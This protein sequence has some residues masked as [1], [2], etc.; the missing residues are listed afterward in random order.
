MLAILCVVSSASATNLKVTVSEL[1]SG[2]ELIPVQGAQISV[3]NF[4]KGSTDTKGC[5]TISISPNVN[6]K[7]SAKKTVGSKTFC[8]SKTI[9]VGN[10]RSGYA[11]GISIRI[12][13]GG[14]C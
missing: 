9:K 4:Y 11:P 13:A 7:I 5:F 10:P 8:G 1:R 6:H 2:S 3:D 14:I 12:I